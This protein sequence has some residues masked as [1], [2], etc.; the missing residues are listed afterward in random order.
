M[1]EIAMLGLLAL[2]RRLILHSSRP[3]RIT[4]PRNCDVT[5]YLQLHRG[6]LVAINRVEC[7]IEHVD[8]EAITATYA[9]SLDERGA[10]VAA[11]A[12]PH[13]ILHDDIRTLR[14]V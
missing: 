5:D 6:T 7:V 13:R 2:C 1:K 4:L 3:L 11:G 14:V 9:Q 8:L 12:R 10:A